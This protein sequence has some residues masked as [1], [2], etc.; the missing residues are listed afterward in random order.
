TTGQRTAPLPGPVP[1]SDTGRERCWQ[2]SWRQISVVPSRS[3]PGWRDHTRY[4]AVGNPVVKVTL[5]GRHTM[6][7]DL[8]NQLL[9]EYH[10]LAGVKTWT[11]DPAGNRLSQDW[12][13][14]GVRSLT[15]WVYDAADE[16]VTETTG[17]SVTTFTFD[18]AGNE[19]V[20]SAPGG[21]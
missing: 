19:Q 20:V 13:Q 15:N 7:Y 21:I 9:S 4:D 10:P 12:T 5:D 14:A 6:T 11:F 16:L 17:A 8:T 2:R 1:S 18:Q 3:R